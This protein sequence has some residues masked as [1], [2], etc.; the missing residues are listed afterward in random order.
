MNQNFKENLF[1]VKNKGM[2]YL[3]KLMDQFIKDNLMKIK[4]KDLEH[5]F[6]KIKNSIQVN[7]K[8]I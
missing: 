4:Y 8:I 1:K 5:A 2:E 3:N 7:G 6:L